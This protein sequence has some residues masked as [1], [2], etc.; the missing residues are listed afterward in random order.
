MRCLRWRF[1]VEQ[2]KLIISQSRWM[3]DVKA[4]PSGT[5]QLLNIETRSEW[6]SKTGARQLRRLLSLETSLEQ[7]ETQFPHQ[8]TSSF[9]VSDAAPHDLEC[10]ANER[11]TQ[12][13]TEKLIVRKEK[14][15][16]MD[17]SPQSP[18][19]SVSALAIAFQHEKCLPTRF[20]YYRLHSGES[21]INLK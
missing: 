14:L 8:K 17:F 15:N 6:M 20:L 11:I 4:L 10:K 3:I 19:L 12:R 2:Q 1:M 5:A 7:E 16:D 9:F 13:Q 18:L 21:S